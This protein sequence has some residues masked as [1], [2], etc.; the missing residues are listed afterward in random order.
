MSFWRCNSLGVLTLAAGIVTPCL[1]AV[2]AHAGDKIEFSA[3]STTLEV[4]QV[5]RE[6]KD[7][8]KTVV[9]GSLQV[10][11]PTPA[12]DA[13]NATTDVV[14]FSAPK[15]KDFRTDSLYAD[16][17]NTDNVGSGQLLL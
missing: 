6:K 3:P 5:P 14:V 13:Q 17:L 12:E 1:L 2:S 8:L 9:D 15:K 16:P 4:P 10:D 7:N 11:A